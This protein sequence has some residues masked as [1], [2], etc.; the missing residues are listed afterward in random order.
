MVIFNIGTFDGVSKLFGIYNKSLECR[1][2]LSNHFKLFS[3]KIGVVDCT[4]MVGFIIASY[5]NQTAKTNQNTIL[6]LF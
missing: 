3:S 4:C 6:Q 5:K 2:I 1:I